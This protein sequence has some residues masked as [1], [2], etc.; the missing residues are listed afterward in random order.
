MF[1]RFQ[2]NRG[3]IAQKHAMNAESRAIQ[4]IGF[5]EESDSG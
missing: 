1:H 5:R 4:G 3:D 2:V